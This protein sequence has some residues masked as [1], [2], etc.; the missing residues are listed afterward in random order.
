MRPTCDHGWMSVYVAV[1]LDEL[2]FGE[3]CRFV[4]HVRAVG[5][6]PDAMLNYAEHTLLPAVAQSWMCSRC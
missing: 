2:T 4:D 3:A 5:V 1:H 6:G